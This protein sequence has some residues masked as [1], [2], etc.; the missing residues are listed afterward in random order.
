MI[1]GGASAVKIAIC[2]DNQDLDYNAK[3]SQILTEYMKKNEIDDYIIEP[4]T[5]GMDLVKAFNQGAYD[6]I[7]LDV[8]M[9]VLDGFET[10][11]SIRQLDL[12]V[13]II[14]ITQANAQI[15]MGYWYGAKDYIC[16]PISQQQIDD[17]MDRLLHE[18]FKKANEERYSIRVKNSGEVDLRL[19]DVFYFESKGHS[20]WAIMKA[21]K[22]E[23]LGKL[24]Q[25][26]IDL[27]RKDF[28]RIHKSYLINMHHIFTM[29]GNRAIFK[30]EII[31]LELNISRKYKDTARDTYMTYRGRG[32]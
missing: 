1:A 24:D 26:E 11:Q 14:F 4:Y 21:D 29:V 3:L 23:F 17:L 28:V 25:I 12:E 20:I 19:T 2:D 31:D 7:F 27:Y 10:A 15:H 16:K 9:P 6:F 32:R 8:R 13:S 30:K 18:R 5:S 22:Y